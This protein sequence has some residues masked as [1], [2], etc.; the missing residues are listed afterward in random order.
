MGL[1]P[2]EVS[3]IEERHVG[4]TL[5]RI[6]GASSVLA[7]IVG[8]GWF[9]GGKSGGNQPT[10]VDRAQPEAGS[11]TGGGGGGEGR[12]TSAESRPE[13]GRHSGSADLVYKFP[14]QAAAQGFATANGISH[15]KIQ[16][17]EGK[18]YVLV[19]RKASTATTVTPGVSTRTS[20][21]PSFSS[22]TARELLRPSTQPGVH[23]QKTFSTDEEAQ[24]Y[25]NSWEYPTYRVR[26]EYMNGQYVVT[27]TK[28]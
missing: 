24:S 15:D 27:V 20:P 5:L 2:G 23:A 12:G 21:P 14:N 3:T 19:P 17:I 13:S 18:Y 11:G 7:A 8:L 1:Q 26:K 6:A 28:N 22:D 16:N 9:G 4:R 25:A 10:G